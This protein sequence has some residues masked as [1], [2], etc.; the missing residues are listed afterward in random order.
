MNDTLFDKLGG[1]GAVNAAVEIFYRK[2][3]SDDRISDFFDDVD[4]DRQAAKQRAFLT[5]AFGGPNQ[6]SGMDM[7]RGHAHLVAKGLNDAHFDA[8]VENLA[9]T[10]QELNVPEAHIAAVAALCETTRND[11]LG[12]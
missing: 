5:M 1:D 11:I 8:V 2:V 3:L 7:R 4:M 10:L 12:K 6:Y 9:A